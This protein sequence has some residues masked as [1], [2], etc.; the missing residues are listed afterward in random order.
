MINFGLLIIVH[1][2]TITR[3]T[4]LRTSTAAHEH[5]CARAPLRTST[6]AHEHRCAE[7]HSAE[8]KKK[9]TTR[10]DCYNDRDQPVRGVGDLVNLASS[11]TRSH[12]FFIRRFS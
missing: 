10:F 12:H 6:A 7:H 1:P 3:T 11:R 2:S 8:H 4:A 5:R 9:I